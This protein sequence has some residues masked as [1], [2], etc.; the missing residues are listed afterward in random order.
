MR[1][2]PT[3]LMLGFAAALFAFISLIERHVP[4]TGSHSGL[5]GRLID[6]R[7]AEITSLQLRRTNQFMFK[8][9]RTN[10]AWN[11]T[12]PIYYPA[13]PIPIEH[14]LELLSEL[15]SFNKIS[16]KDLSDQKRTVAEFGLDIPA[17][18]VVLSAGGKRFEIMFGSK[19]SVGD[20]VYVQLL[21]SPD[22]YVV[23]TDC[24]DALPPNHQQWRD[25]ALLS[26]AGLKPDRFELRSAGRGYAIQVDP[27]NGEFVLTKPTMARANRARVTALL[28]KIQE[29]P[30]A[31][32]V[33]ESAQE[34]LDMYG[35]Q[36]PVAEL[37]FGVGTNDVVTVQFG[38]ATNDLV[39]ARRLANTN[40]VTVSKAFFESLLFSPT[41]LRDKRL[42]SFTPEQVDTIEV[43]AQEKFMVQRQG[44]NSW[45]V[46]A[47]QNY[48][49]DPGLVREWL[50]RLATIEAAT[51]E[52]DVVTDFGLYGLAPAG[53]QYLLKAN[54]TNVTGNVTNRLL[55]QLALSPIQNQ[56]VFARALEDS[57]YSLELGAIDLLPTAAW[58]LRDRRVWSFS[59]NQIASV[60][61]RHQGYERKVERR[62]NS[63]WVLTKG[64]GIID[65]ARIEESMFRLGNLKAAAW[66]EKSDANRVLYGF[67]D[68][69][70]K[71]TV[72]LK[73]NDKPQ[74]FSLEFGGA[75]P[76]QFPYAIANVDGHNMIFEFPLDL[77]FFVANALKNP[78]QPAQ[79]SLR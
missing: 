36:P 18:T 13:Q 57:V 66:V 70:Y 39:Y 33:L 56:K 16:V 55:A 64:Q 42:L 14:V 74:T 10:D 65:T 60:T 43:D 32:F 29:E 25:I 12:S 67:K 47:T 21:N 50:N 9:E 44:P 48:N 1:W 20:R 19:N 77:F 69:G 38:K 11:L 27:T 34:E 8:V 17:A 54:L 22:I 40:V 59:T 6:F 53:R 63:N 24:Y 75:A 76:S 51:V 26:L 62:G 46:S 23:P 73:G 2:K 35:L 58:Q 72:E 71:L 15:K 61:I 52:K 3:W 45:T 37:V 79:A 30:V 49:A 4:G 28:R 7:P 78:A 41:D 68:D 31:G 5:P